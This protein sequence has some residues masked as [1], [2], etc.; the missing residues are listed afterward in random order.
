MRTTTV[1]LACIL[2]HA[3]DAS[4]Q[5][6]AVPP[7]DP[8]NALVRRLERTL[9]SNDRPGFPTLF[10]PTVSNDSITQHGFDLFV[11]GAVRTAL[12]E[13]SRGP[14]EHLLPI[15]LAAICAGAAWFV[16]PREEGRA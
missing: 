16:F 6:Q 14:L 13:R 15:L 7:G 2:W 5:A 10:A 3:T 12:F 4:A 8:V 9:N 11:P 1:V